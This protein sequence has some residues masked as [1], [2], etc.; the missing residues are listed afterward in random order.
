[1]SVKPDISLIVPVYNVEPYLT[2]CVESIRRQ[3]FDA[4]EVLLVD[5]GSTD[6]SSRIC[7]LMASGDSRFR[8]IHRQNGGTSVARNAGVAAARGRYIAFMDSDDVI[9]TSYLSRL[10]QIAVDSD[11]DIAMV[12]FAEGESLDF[13]KMSLSEKHVAK[14]SPTV[15]LERTLYQDGLD[16]SPCCKLYRRHLFES[17]SF[18][19]GILYEDLDF[20]SRILPSV[21]KVAV[22][23]DVL[24]YYRHRKGSN[25]GSFTLK[26]LDV[27]DVTENICKR[28]E[29]YSESLQL[30][31]RDRRLSAAFNMFILLG[32][33]GYGDSP[34]SA[35]CWDMIR[36]LRGGELFNGKV[37]LKNKLGVLLSYGGRR[38]FSLISRIVIL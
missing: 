25:I 13:S 11:A 8:V 3:D 16:T 32:A 2:E 38:L 37:R 33:N 6:G 21:N 12:K 23:D 17:F 10:Y 28:V 24:Y 19:P 20:I 27:L 22:S 1:M 9:H 7:D 4:F 36:S 5:D 30:A 18:I 35:R 14:L 26:R 29:Q 15:A 34:A 31:A